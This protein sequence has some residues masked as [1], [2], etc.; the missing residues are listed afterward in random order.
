[1]DLQTYRERREAFF[2]RYAALWPGTLPDPFDL[3]DLY[4][5]PRA[6][7]AAITQAASAIALIYKR[8]AALLR[9]VPDK[10]LLQMGLPPETLQLALSQT[11]GMPDTVI[12]RF[13]LVKTT[14]G[15]KL[16]EFNADVPGML[17][18]TFAI[19]AK[20]CEE[21][22]RVDPNRDGEPMLAAALAQALQAGL[23]YVGKRQD[24]PALVVFTS[25]ERSNRERDIQ[26]YLMNLLARTDNVRKQYAPVESLRV[27]EQG[28]CDPAGHPIDILYRSY[29]LQYL[30]RNLAYATSDGSGAMH[31]DHLSHLVA[32][33]RL[34]L[35]NPPSAFLL[36]GKAVQVVIWG[37]FE[38]G[39]YF[40]EAER[41]LIARHLLP[42][43]LDPVFEDERYVSKPVYGSE[44]NTI[45]IIDPEL[46]TLTNSSG[47]TYAEQPMVYQ[48]Y[49]EL[50]R[51]ELMTEDGPR[52]LQV[53]TSCFL[54]ADQPV[55]IC[56]RA[57]HEITD[58]SW[59]FLPVCVA[60]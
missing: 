45:A 24:E 11:H 49:T 51:V 18:E 44:G 20:A 27:N 39:M 40:D 17:I 37:L 4:P 46:G 58:A 59:W 14:S 36:E 7:V 10:A 38:S 12:G 9:T 22:G 42:T 60:D 8:T 16:L 31:V 47:Q 41:A 5:L 57:G 26:L 23:A 21:E 28:L 1:V 55:G 53:L 6:E 54:I 34:A 48:Q 29:P 19:N 30:Q 25:I 32:E 43:Y 35:V 33:H 15:Y 3:L 50:P 13:D 56:L 52:R 2:A